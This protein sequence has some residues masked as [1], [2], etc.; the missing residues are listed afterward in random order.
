MAGG[1]VGVPLFDSHRRPIG[2]MVALFRRRLEDP[3]LAEA[4]LKM[5]RLWKGFSADDL[6][7][8]AAKFG[9]GRFKEQVRQAVEDAYY[10]NAIPSPR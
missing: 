7:Q 9:R 1:Y 3:G 4:I 6:V 8:N 5:E 10:R 2:N